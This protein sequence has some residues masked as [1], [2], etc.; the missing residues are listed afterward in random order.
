MGYCVSVFDSS[1]ERLIVFLEGSEVKLK[2]AVRHPALKYRV[3][4]WVMHQFCNKICKVPAIPGTFVIVGYILW[5]LV[6]LLQFRLVAMT[7][8]LKL[9]H[10]ASLEAD[11]LLWHDPQ[12]FSLVVFQC[13]LSV[14]AT[15]VVEN[16][17]KRPSI[18]VSV[19]SDGDFS[20]RSKIPPHFLC[21]L[22]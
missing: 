18:M 5:A 4:P 3:L 14:T 10:E 22:F 19:L 16:C 13:L 20:W 12:S 1:G 2:L 11:V 8:Q 9:R 17:W 6:K 15:H 21:L 7:H